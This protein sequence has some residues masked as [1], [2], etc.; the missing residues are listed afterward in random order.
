M[1]P[2]DVTQI[3]QFIVI[4]ILSSIFQSIVGDPSSFIG[5]Q[6]LSSLYPAIHPDFVGCHAGL[7][8]K[9]KDC[10]LASRSTVVSACQGVTCNH[11]APL[12]ALLL[13]PWLVPLARLLN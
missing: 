12:S 3:A 10:S 8:S 9:T 7:K 6:C 2:V 13:A 1:F 5:A 11:L 4:E